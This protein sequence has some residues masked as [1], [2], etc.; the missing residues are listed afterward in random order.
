MLPRMGRASSP[1]DAG[2]TAA[3]GGVVAVSLGG[4][5][6]RKMRVKSGQG[7]TPADIFP[8]FLSSSFVAFGT[9]SWMIR[10]LPVDR[11]ASINQYTH[12]HTHRVVSST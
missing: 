6:L 8:I 7:R 4:T 10:F 2:V 5:V 1:T 3:G 9:K 11:P 12:T